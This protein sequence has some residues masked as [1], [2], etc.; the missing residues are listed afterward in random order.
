M[1]IRPAPPLHTLG[2]WIVHVSRSITYQLSNGT[3]PKGYFDF[4]LNEE[5]YARL[6][7]GREEYEAKGLRFAVVTSERGFLCS[8][9]LGKG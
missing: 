7:E 6:E 5:E 1:G 8:H 4:F 9:Q 3:G 2:N